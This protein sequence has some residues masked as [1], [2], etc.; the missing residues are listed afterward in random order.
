M[1]RPLRREL[2]GIWSA[3]RGPYRVIY[4]IDDETA[5]RWPPDRPSCRRL[6]ALTI[7]LWVASR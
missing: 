1:G 7:I 6:P 5:R 3:R 2:A 4:E